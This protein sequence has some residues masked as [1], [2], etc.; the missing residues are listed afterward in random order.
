MS[1]RDRN[2]R[3]TATVIALGIVAVTV[4]AFAPALEAPFQ[5][6]DV[7]SIEQ[8]QTA[9][10]LWPLAVPLRPPPG[11]SVAGRPVVNLSLAINYAVNDRLGMDQRPDPDGSHK[12]VGY[13]VFN[14]LLHLACGVL[15]F[16]VARRTLNNP[17]L[18]DGWAQRADAMAAII[19]SLWLLHPIQTEAV[20]YIIQRTELLASA[21]YLLTLYA[22]IRAGEAAER[23]PKLSWYSIAA[24]SCFLGMGSKEVAITAPLIVV[25]YDWTFQRDTWREDVRRGR[26]L[27]YLALVATVGGALWMF[28]AGARS[29]TVGFDLGMPWYRY[30]YSQAWAIVHYVR[31]VLWPNKLTFDYGTAPVRGLQ[32]VPGLVLLSAAGIATVVGI[33]RARWFGFLGAW[34]FLLLAPSSSVVPIVSE[35]A[36]ERRIY[37]ALAALIVLVVVTCDVARRRLQGESHFSRRLWVNGAMLLGAAGLCLVL[38]AVT[39]E[40]S[41]MYT[42]P[43]ALWRDAAEKM[44]VNP[45]AYDNLASVIAAMGPPRA[46]EAESLYRRAIA[47]DSMYSPAW[48]NLAVVL[49]RSGRTDSARQVLER[50]VRVNPKD[51]RTIARLGAMLEKGGDNQ[52]AIPYLERAAAVDPDG[53]TLAALGSAYLAVGRLQEASLVFRRA[54]EIDPSR[55]DLLR[56]L[57]GLLAD[58]GQPGAAAYLEEAVRREP[59]SGVAVAMLSLAYAQDGRLDESV[60]AAKNAV[61]LSPNRPQIQILAGRAMLIAQRPADAERHFSEAVRLD[62]S[63]PESLTRRGIARAALGDR[64]AESD[65]RRALIV[66]PGYPPALRA[67]DQ[68]KHQKP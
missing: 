45:R 17:V 41:R 46:A 39:F 67:L 51:V 56:A 64:R 29:D 53:E 21:C 36:A 9:R 25:L 3:L 1:D 18:G 19:A 13:H 31:L 48:T 37:L 30:L 40:R 42:H 49:D 5:F 22:S 65:F 24:V 23:A 44:P 58:A 66:S 62:P 61:S 7:A 55:T 35:I 60:T 4:I 50:A 34:F 14:L 2:P 38:G 11:T 12:T 8:N 33:V 15:L 28:S 47:V 32:G 68:L 10:R 43:E 26:G 59:T 6:D 52:R 54:L 27:F 20:N 16:L 57:G 63:N